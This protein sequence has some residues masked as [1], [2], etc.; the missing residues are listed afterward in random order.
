PSAGARRSPARRWRRPARAPS[1]P[2]R[3]SGPE[4]LQ[5]PRRAARRGPVRGDRRQASVVPGVL[6]V[7]R[8]A[9]LEERVA[10]FAGFVRAVGEARR[11]SREELLPDEAFVWQVE[12]VLEHAHRGRALLE[13]LPAPLERGSL[14]LAVRHDGVDHAPLERLLGRVAVA[15]EEDLARALLAAL[16]GEQ[17]GAVPSAAA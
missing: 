5:G 10:P 9:L 7:V 15:E 3:S 11:F 2:R 17:P 12:P 14:E 1:Y 4:G 16:T 6:P 8:R 13:D